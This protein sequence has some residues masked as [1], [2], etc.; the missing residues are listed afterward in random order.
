M[1][2]N[3]FLAAAAALLLNA[4]ASHITSVTPLRG[5]PGD[6]FTIHGTNLSA[7]LTSV[8]P[9]RPQLERCE[10]ATMPVLSWSGTQ[11]VVR[12][13]SGLPAGVYQVVAFSG[14]PFNRTNTVDFWVTAASVDASVTDPYEVQVRSYAKRWS[15]APDWIAFMLANRARYQAAFDAAHALPCPVKIAAS[16]ESPLVYTPPWAGENEHM[17]ALAAM[18][19]GGYPG[20]HVKFSLDPAGAYTHAFLGHVDPTSFAGADGVHLHWETIFL[21]EFGHI[22]HLLH[23]YDSEATVGEHQHMPPGELHC[24]MDRTGNQFCS[25]CRTALNL[26]LD[27]D[28]GAAID[29][30]TLN[31]I[32]RYPPGW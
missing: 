12:I 14:P 2:T 13:P 4:C 17:A 21:H 32:T 31:I 22:L 29:S 16:Y 3:L 23:H 1:R 30:V 27:V 18:T 25:A 24:T 6:V 5:A 11:I 20:Y 8:P 26:P 28:N 7:A 19:E 10:S 15:K 9:H